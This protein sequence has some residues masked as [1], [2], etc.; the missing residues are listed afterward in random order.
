[1]SEQKFYIRKDVECECQK[2][3]QKGCYC[4]LGSGIV[5]NELVEATSKDFEKAGWVKREKCV[6]YTETDNNNEP[7]YETACGEAFCF[8]V[9]NPKNNNM[10]FCPYCG[11]E[12]IWKD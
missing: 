9:G 2:T 11:S 5:E 4:C 8:I 3:E 6:W 7:Y 10:K 1:M 12:L